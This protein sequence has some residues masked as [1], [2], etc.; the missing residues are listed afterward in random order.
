MI[1][2]YRCKKC[3]NIQESNEPPKHIQF[4]DV[5][6]AADIPLY[7]INL[8]EMCFKDIIK[9]LNDELLRREHDDISEQNYFWKQSDG[10][11]L[12]L[13]EMTDRHL[14]N[15]LNKITLM[16]EN[17]ETQFKPVSNVS[18]KMPF[19]KHK[20]KL[21]TSLPKE[22]V[23]WLLKQS[24]IKNPLRTQLEDMIINKY[25]KQI[26]QGYIS[27]FYQERTESYGYCDPN[28]WDDDF[29]DVMSYCLPN[30]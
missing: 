16:L 17:G 13:S 5:C 21:L 2:V 24:S 4:C 7:G 25:R 11:T 3:G 14:H 22:Y 19:G 15:L 8:N 1:Y 29:A 28:D 26:I 6:E 12:E 27:K 10:N 30:T 18:P 9:I 20:G 23:A